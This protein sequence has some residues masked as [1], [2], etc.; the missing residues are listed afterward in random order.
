MNL[1]E[2]Y[3]PKTIEEFVG[4]KKVI[5]TLMKYVENNIPTILVGKPGI[6]KT[7]A[8]YIV[9]NEL[10][11][12]VI[13]TNASDERRKNELKDL[14]SRLRMKTF[15]KN[16]F[17]LDEIDGLE[18][19]DLLSGYIMDSHYP[20]VMTANEKYKVSPKITKYCKMIEMSPPP[21]AL[22]VKRMKEIAEKEGVKVTYDRVSTD[23]RASINNTFYEGNGYNED[24]NNFEKVNRVFRAKK[25]EDI[26]LIWLLDNVHN[27]YHGKD[28]YNSIKILSKVEET[29]NK[30]LL[31]CLPRAK[32]GRPGYP[33]ML[34]R[35]KK[36]RK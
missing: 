30:E 18:N 26:P 2:K 3:R 24:K 21:L 8:V 20:I 6:G 16:L 9:A 33:Y 4:D 7:S 28:L 10:D 25:V 32:K 15:S 5:E 17:L 31:S 14:G 1:T 12:N 29:K 13:E 22:V 35:Y 27:F 11:Y 36:T 19:Q 34:R 23:V